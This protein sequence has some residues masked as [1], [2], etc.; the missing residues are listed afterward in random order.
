MMPRRNPT[1][2]EWPELPEAETV[3]L[4]AMRTWV[5]GHRC[6]RPVEQCISPV[7]VD[8]GAPGAA[9]YLYGLMWA[10]SHGAS[11]RIAV[12]CPLHPQMSE[13]EQT[14]LD[15]LA[16][17][18]DGQ[19]FERLLLLRTLLRPQAATPAGAS[20]TRLVQECNRAGLFLSI[21][22]GPLR[23]LAFPAR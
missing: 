6:G 1:H 17:T 23:H 11:R 7:F 15:V 19:T 10:L 20:A 21:E 22:H 13:D 8:L 2:E 18:Q 5:A 14:L 12:H 16:L 3:L 4:W 9:S